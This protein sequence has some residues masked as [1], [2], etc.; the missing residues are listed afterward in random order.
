MLLDDQEAGFDALVG[1]AVPHHAGLPGIEGMAELDHLAGVEGGIVVEGAEAVVAVVDQASADF[2]V[3]GIVE[4]E[5]ERSLAAV[6][7]FNAA[8]GGVEAGGNR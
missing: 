4:G 6:A 1:N 5:L 8:V 7:L 3:R 2:L